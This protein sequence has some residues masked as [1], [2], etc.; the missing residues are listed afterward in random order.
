MAMVDVVTSLLIRAA[1]ADLQLKSV[2][3]V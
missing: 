1:Q 2:S 3:L